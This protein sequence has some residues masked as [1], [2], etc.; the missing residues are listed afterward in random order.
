MSQDQTEEYAI[1]LALAE[2]RCAEYLD[3]PDNFTQDISQIECEKKFRRRVIKF[4]DVYYPDFP[5]WLRSFLQTNKEQ[6]IP[7]DI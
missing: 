7:V 1:E 5:L 2:D 3:N 4:I 6:S